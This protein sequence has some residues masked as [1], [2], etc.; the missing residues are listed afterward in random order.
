MGGPRNSRRSKLDLYGLVDRA[1][2]L[3]DQGHTIAEIAEILQA[4]GYDISRESIRRRLK[5]AREVS[6]L[7]KKSLQEAKI[8]LEAVKDAPNT[9]VV[10]VTNSL[11]AHRMFDFAKSVEDLNFQSPIEF[12]RAVR[13]LADAQVKVARLRLDFQKGFKAAKR[14][15]LERVAKELEN[16]PDLRER[17]CEII[18][19]VDADNK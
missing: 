18:N 16:H 17:L 12:V 3:Y 8:L 15:I 11:L 10:E 19:Q 4:D 9:D 1:M 2:E 14:E 7:Y 13:T 6:E 5:T